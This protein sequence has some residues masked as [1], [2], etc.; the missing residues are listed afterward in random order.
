MQIWCV[1]CGAWNVWLLGD[2]NLINSTDA[3]QKW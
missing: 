1:S 3:L 2:K